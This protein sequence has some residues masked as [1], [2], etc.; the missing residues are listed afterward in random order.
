MNITPPWSGQVAD[1]D[2]L[3]HQGLSKSLRKVLQVRVG[4]HIRR[5]CV[6]RRKLLVLCQAQVNILFLNLGVE[7][8]QNRQLELTEKELNGSLGSNSGLHVPEDHDERDG[9]AGGEGLR[10]PG[11]AELRVRRVGGADAGGPALGGRVDVDGVFGPLGECLV[12]Y[13]LVEG[14]WVAEEGVLTAILSQRVHGF[15]T[16]RDVTCLKLASCSRI[17]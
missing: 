1:V 17:L 15:V 2:A 9:L 4:H 8:A 14:V 12:E 11:E 6:P 5:R 3:S 10:E 16:C 7:R 13:R